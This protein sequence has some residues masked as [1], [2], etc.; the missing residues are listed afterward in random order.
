VAAVGLFVDAG[1]GEIASTASKAG[2]DTIQLHGSERPEVAGEVRGAGF[3]TVKVFRVS[4]AEDLSE[5]DAYAD[6]VDAYLVDSRV[7]GASGG[8]GVAA[9]WRIVAE[10]S[11]PRPLILAGGLMPA[12]VAEAIRVVR[13]YGVDVSSGIE[14]SPGV[15]DRDLMARFME[16]VRS[17]ES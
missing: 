7:E 8:T 16:A 11:Y 9:P 3:R 15:K 13:P 2:F 14:A 5:V 1:A 10:R 12:N 4:G 17:A 6:A